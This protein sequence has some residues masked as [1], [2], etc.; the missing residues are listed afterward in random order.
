MYRLII[1]DYSVLF[2]SNVIYS[3]RVHQKYSVI[4]TLQLIYFSETIKKEM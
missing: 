2:I 1:P 3:E 4:K